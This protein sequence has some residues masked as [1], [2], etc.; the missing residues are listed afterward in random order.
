MK[1]G[2]PECLEPDHHL[3]QLPRPPRRQDSEIS[4]R[5]DQHDLDIGHRG[6]QSLRHR[7]GVVRGAVAPSVLRVCKELSKGRLLRFIRVVTTTRLSSSSSF[8]TATLSFLL[9]LQSSLLNLKR[10]EVLLEFLHE[11]NSP[12]Y[13][14]G[15]VT[16]QQNFN[17]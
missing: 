7:R 16:L 2:E 3:E 10:L 17:K 5:L 9:L 1:Y 12:P 13:D 15:L 4:V 14:G 8:T 6:R 11:I